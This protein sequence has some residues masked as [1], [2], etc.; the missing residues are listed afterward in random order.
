MTHDLP[1]G[2]GSVVHRVTV[3]GAVT[4]YADQFLRPRTGMTE[5]ES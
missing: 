5:D 2:V 3:S 4:E 1:P